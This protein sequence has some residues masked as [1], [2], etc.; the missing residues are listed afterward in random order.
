M[1]GVDATMNRRGGACKCGVPISK[2]ML[3]RI[4]RYS[5]MTLANMFAFVCDENEYHQVPKVFLFELGRV[6]FSFSFLSSLIF[7]HSDAM[8]N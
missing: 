7:S 3:D 4:S 8:G 5:T 1:G 2:T 6:V